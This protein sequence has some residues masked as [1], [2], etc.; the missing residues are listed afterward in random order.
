MR[1]PHPLLWKRKGNAP[2]DRCVRPS[3]ELNNLVLSIRTPRCTI[4]CCVR[5]SFELSLLHYADMCVLHLKY[6][7]PPPMVQPLR[8]E[9]EI[10]HLK[11]RPV[12][13]HSSFTKQPPR[14]YMHV[15]TFPVRLSPPRKSGRPAVSRP[16]VAERGYHG[17]P[18]Q[19]SLASSTEDNTA[20]LLGRFQ[21]QDSDTLTYACRL[22][23]QRTIP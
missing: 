15:F 10:N 20:C 7:P 1:P 21:R 16:F 22:D 18:S 9:K 8:G 17:Q 14:K 3:F 11:G 4:P 23:L 13:I 19:T 2:A 12:F 6:P 5:P